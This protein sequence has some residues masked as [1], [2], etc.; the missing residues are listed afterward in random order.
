[1][2]LVLLCCVQHI[3]MGYVVKELTLSNQVGVPNPRCLISKP[4][5]SAKSTRTIGGHT[6]KGVESLVPSHFTFTI[7]ELLITYMYFN[8]GTV[9]WQ[10]I[11]LLDIG[12]P[13][14]EV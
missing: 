10:V 1:M 11:L 7:C 13:P 4:V 9:T 3:F 14:H 8:Y 12:E 5:G 6:K 2:V